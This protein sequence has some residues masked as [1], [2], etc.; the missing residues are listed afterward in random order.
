MQRATP[1]EGFMLSEDDRRMLVARSDE[2]I[3]HPER[4]VPYEEVRERIFRD[5]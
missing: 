3:A 1:E 4:G 2:A 5:V